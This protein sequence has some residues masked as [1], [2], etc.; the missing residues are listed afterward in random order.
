M[1]RKRKKPEQA[2][3]SYA[4][5][6]QQT[7]KNNQ[8]HTKSVSYANTHHCELEIQAAYRGLFAERAILT[9][10][11]NRISQK[12]NKNKDPRNCEIKCKSKRGCLMQDQAKPEVASD[13]FHR[14][15]RAYKLG[16]ESGLPNP[17]TNKNQKQK[18]SS[19]R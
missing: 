7:H 12:N 1:V 8:T 13:S 9:T 17:F 3:A 5:A 14:A 6:V 19:N 15:V 4:E 2:V 11:A 18:T 10:K 16:I